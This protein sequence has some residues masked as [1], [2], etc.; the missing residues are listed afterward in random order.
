M[1]SPAWRSRS[2]NWRK[3]SCMSVSV[4]T[5]VN[6]SAL[7][8]SGNPAAASRKA[9]MQL[10]RIPVVSNHL[11]ASWPALCRPSTFC[12]TLGKKGVDGRDE[13]GPD[14]ERAERNKDRQ[15]YGEDGSNPTGRAL[16]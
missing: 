15:Y 10:I 3:F 12:S 5:A 2:R 8:A 7:L 4:T 6:L 16:G 9:A 13:R 1:S 11:S 14:A